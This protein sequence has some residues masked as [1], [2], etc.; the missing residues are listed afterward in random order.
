M[1]NCLP[2]SLLLLCL[3]VSFKVSFNSKQIFQQM[4][5][6]QGTWVMREKQ[7]TLLFESWE[8]INDSL[9]QGKSYVLDEKNM[10]LIPGETVQLKHTVEGIFYVPVVNGQNNGLP[11]SFKLTSAENNKFV[12]E[13]AEHDFPKRI[14][15]V[16]RSKES[17]YAYVDG[18]PKDSTKR[19]DYL[20]QH[21]K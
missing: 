4:Y 21:I 20:Y 10:K 13:N 6:L 9:L 5:A 16:L 1:K 3:L 18:G 12:F 19:I 17:L 8:K 2:Y 7:N 15:Y 14:V 11:V